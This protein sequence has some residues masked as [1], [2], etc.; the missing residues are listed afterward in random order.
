MGREITIQKGSVPQEKT[1]AIR[2]GIRALHNGLTLRRSL[3]IL[4]LAL[5]WTEMS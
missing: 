1:E 2:G 4:F 3:G 5:T